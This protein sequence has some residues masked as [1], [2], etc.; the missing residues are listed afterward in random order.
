[1]NEIYVL[2]EGEFE[3]PVGAFKNEIDAK[4]IGQLDFWKYA[5]YEAQ[6]GMSLES[7]IW[8]F[9]FKVEKLDFKNGCID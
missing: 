1:M 8:E 9:D 4:R 3:K 2:L 5:K 7:V 6:Y